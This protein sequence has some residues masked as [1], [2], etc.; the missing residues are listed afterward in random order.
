MTTRRKFLT[1]IGHAGGYGAT[2]FILQS[3]G[4]L[5]VPPT[6]A[7]TPRLPENS[8]KG[9]TVVILGAG[10]SGMVAAWEL[11]KAGYRCVILEARGR[12]GGRN[13]TIRNGTRVD[14]TDGTSQTCTWD[15]SSYFNAGPARLPSQHLT[16]LGYCREFGVPL[17]VEVNTSRSSLMQSA[18]L[19][20]GKPVQQREVVNDTRGHV[21]ELLAKAV[22]RGAL[23]QELSPDDKERMLEFLRTYGDL[24]PDNFYK[25]S[26]R[27]GYKVWPAAGEQGGE[28]RDPLDMHAL[29]DANLWYGML[30]EEQILWQATMF[31]PIGGMDRIPAAFERRLA[32]LI[33]SHSQV[34]QIRKTPAGVRVA[35]RDGR[36]GATHAIE[37]DYCICS[38]PFSVLKS[39]DA[40]FSPDLKAIIDATTYDRAYKMAWES[41]RFW[42]RDDAIYGGISFLNQPVDL[43]WYPSARLFSEKGVIIAGY[44]MENGSPLEAMDLRAKLAASRQSVELLHPGR[45]QE[46]AKPICVC[47]GRIPYNLGSWVHVNEPTMFPGYERAIQPDGPIFLC[48]EH[49]SHIVGWQEGAALSAH[50]AVSL[51]AQSRTSEPART[52]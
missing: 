29:L 46:M 3:L 14:M 15:E 48:G 52:A 37:A 22:G 42:E 33:R 30:Y 6:Q 24:S 1:Q 19:N 23:D 43:V 44:G 39:I 51:L 9:K 47:W 10:I 35:Y 40:D 26:D 18:G 2:Y 28:I 4:L 21:S 12:T 20:R 8:G 5:P 17:E 31:Q 16:M 36:T 41:P 27:S 32:H 25:G 13:W 50:R 45:S 34:E 38:I 7:S 49:L 11:S